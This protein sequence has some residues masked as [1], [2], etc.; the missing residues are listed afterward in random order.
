[1][2]EGISQKMEGNSVCSK[3]IVYFMI[4]FRQ[5]CVVT[6]SLPLCALL[7]CFVTAYIFQPDDIHETHCRVSTRAQRTKKNTQ[8]NLHDSNLRCSKE[9][10]II[11]SSSSSSLAQQPLLSQGLLQKLLRAVS[12]PCSIPPI[13]LP[14]LPGIFCHT[15]FPSQFRPAPLSSSFY[16]CNENSSC[17]ALFLHTNNMPCPL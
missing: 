7:I 3:T 17:S 15:I 13:S 8:R 1:M 12:I 10:S 16:H 9:K 11:R 5:L 14:Q 2:V 6:V 4:S